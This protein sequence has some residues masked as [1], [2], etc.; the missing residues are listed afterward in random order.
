MAPNEADVE[1]D[2]FING[3]KAE[4]GESFT[5]CCCVGDHTSVSPQRDADLNMQNNM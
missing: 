2:A 1:H 3:A 4:S 5:I